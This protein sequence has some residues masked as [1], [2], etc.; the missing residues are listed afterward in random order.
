MM[1]IARPI[2]KIFGL[3]AVVG[4]IVGW[5][6]I[7]LRVMVRLPPANWV[8]QVGQAGESRRGHHTPYASSVHAVLRGPTLFTG[9]YKRAKFLEDPQVVGAC[10]HAS[11]I[12]QRSK[13]GILQGHTREQG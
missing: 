6:E 3:G 7:S 4:S 9:A 1:K 5:F 12:V 13:V 2:A 11:A 8:A 10:V